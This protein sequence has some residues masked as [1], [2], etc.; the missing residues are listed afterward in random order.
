MP[1]RRSDDAP[2]TLNRTHEAAACG[3]AADAVLRARRRR[4]IA[5]DAVDVQRNS[6]ER[7]GE[8]QRN[9]GAEAGRLRHA[10]VVMF[11]FAAIAAAP[12][13]WSGRVPRRAKDRQGLVPAEG[14]E[15]TTP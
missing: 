10:D 11:P 4:R 5:E 7:V 13:A 3:A 14:L 12:F 6:A 1:K 9:D 2:R 8:G 15:P